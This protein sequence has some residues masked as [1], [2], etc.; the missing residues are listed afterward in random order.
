MLFNSLPTFR[1][2]KTVEDIIQHAMM[3]YLTVPIAQQLIIITTTT[4]Q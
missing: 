2:S 1:L 4:K 3:I